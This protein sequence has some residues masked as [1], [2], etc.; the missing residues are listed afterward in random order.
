MSSNKSQHYIPRFYL[1]NFSNVKNKKTIGLFN[2]KKEIYIPSASIKHQACSSYFYGED[3]VVENNLSKLEGIFSNIITAIIDLNQLPEHFSEA[4]I[5]LLIFLISMIS[6]TKYSAEEINETFDKTFKNIFKEDP[7]L[8][9]SIQNYKIG[10][11]NPATYSLG[12]ALQL[13]PIIFDLEFKLINNNTCTNFITSDNPVIKY[14][15]LL[16]LKKAFGGITGLGEK[17]IQLMIP[18]NSKNYIIFYDQRVYKIGNRKQY[19]ITSNNLKDIDSLN[20]LQFI[21]ANENIYFNETI[22]QDYLEIL[23]SRGKKYI[24]DKKSNL[25]EFPSIEKTKNNKSS[26]LVTYP[27]DIKINLNLSFIKLLKKAK[28]YKLENKAV[29]IRSEKVSQIYDLINETFIKSTRDDQY[30]I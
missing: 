26:L 13:V 14:N 24:R 16:E 12:I 17:G 19:S 4:H 18:I 5:L 8:K 3:G 11:K 6:R 7:R 1:K 10:L 28:R 29:H 20:L 2:I 25:L 30:E 22:K 15:Q 21:N 27:E 9:D 23:L